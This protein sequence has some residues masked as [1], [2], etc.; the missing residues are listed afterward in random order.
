MTWLW[1][2]FFEELP[3]QL[4]ERVGPWLSSN[5]FGHGP[6]HDLAHQLPQDSFGVFC[7]D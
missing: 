4:I 2:A 5:D 1:G 3:A 6:F 7:I